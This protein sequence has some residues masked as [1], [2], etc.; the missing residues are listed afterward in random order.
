MGLPNY[1]P[2]QVRRANP[3]ARR[4]WPLLGQEWMGWISL[5]LFLTGCGGAGRALSMAGPTTIPPRSPAIL[6]SMERLPPPPET[7]A[8]PMAEPQGARQEL[9]TVAASDPE[10]AG[11]QVARL[12]Y[13]EVGGQ[14]QPLPQRPAGKRSSPQEDLPR[15]LDDVAKPLRLKIPVDVPG[16]AAPPLLLPEANDDHPE[17]RQAAIEILFPKPPAPRTL[18]PPTEPSQTLEEL[19]EL[20][21]ANNP[22]LAQAAGGITVSQGGAIQAGIYPNPVFGYEADTVGSFFTRN[23]QGVYLQQVVKTA[24][25][26]NLQ[27]AAANMELLNAQL[28]YQRTRLEVRRQVRASYY[29]VLVAQ[30]ASRINEALLRF[31]TEVYTI[32]VERLKNGEQAPYEP[33]QLRTLVVQARGALVQ[34]QNRY[35]SAWKQLAAATGV[36]DLRPAPLAGRVDMPVPNLDFDTLLAR[37]L[38][39]HPDVQASRNL[40]AQSRYQLRLQQVTPIPDVTVGSA[41]QKDFTTPGFQRTSY[42]LNVSVPLPLFDKNQGNI[43]AAQGRLQISAQQL[44]VTRNQLTFQ[45]SDAFERFQ[46]ARV[47]G[48]FYRTQ[49]LPD[50]ARAYRGVYERHIQKPEAVAFGDIIVAQQNL[51]NGVSNY[52]VTLMQQW[53]AATDIANLLQLENFQELLLLKPPGSPVEPGAELGALGEPA[54]APASPPREGA[55]P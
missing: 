36:P 49:Q 50:L 28:G 52:I 9:Q 10:K 24:G 4:R 5:G 35:I 21:M 23:Y 43:R 22:L 32:M 1:S 39:A 26:L 19:E 20:A 54:A 16:A 15:P 45:L 17:A 55:K 38:S 6:A 41:F 47:L 27:R 18:T 29:N 40:E 30:E 53:Q 46:T 34:S 3:L 14:P 44:G 2:M 8:E 12:I 37:M 48:E 11:S 51:A 31:T 13:H 7:T 33:A 25:K 42:N